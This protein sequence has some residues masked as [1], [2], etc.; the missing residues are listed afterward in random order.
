MEER[1][2]CNVML[3]SNLGDGGMKGSTHDSPVRRGHHISISLSRLVGEL[4]VVFH[5]VCG[6]D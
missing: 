5:G 2:S 1:T 3:A 4:V 6:Q